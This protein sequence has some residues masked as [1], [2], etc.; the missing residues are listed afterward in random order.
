MK[1]G[2]IGVAFGVL[3]LMGT[4]S[5]QSAYVGIGVGEGHMTVP[6]VSTTF[7]GLPV[8]GS[9]D[10]TTDTAWKLYGGYNFTP[11]WGVEIGYNDF[12]NRYSLHGNIGAS[13]FTVNDVKAD[14]W[15]LA[16]TGTLPLGSNFA[17]FAKLG[18]ARNHSDGGS[19]CVAG[20]CL[21]VGSEN[22][23]EVMYGIGASYSFTKNWAAQLEYE[24]YGKM[25]N[26]DFWGTGGSG[27]IKGTAWTLSAKY[28]F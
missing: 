3:G 26:D 16:G 17:L 15:Y 20:A 12:G 7:L 4:A 13:P 25:S 11:N 9:G 1:F 28:S 5:A 27:S 23:S 19:A 6:S 2:A 18:W 14:N 10:K 22:R 24:D 21:S 8:S